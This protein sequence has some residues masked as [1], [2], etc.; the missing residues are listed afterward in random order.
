MRLLNFKWS[1]TVTGAK[2]VTR[3]PAILV[4]NHVDAMD[5]VAIV[6]KQW[7]R[8][9]AFAKIE[10]F[11]N[12]GAIFFRWMGQI[13]LRRGDEESTRWA[14]DMAAQVLA[15]GSMLGLYPEGTRSPDKKSLHKLHRRILIPIFEL[16]PEVPVHAI[17]T[18]YGAKKFGRQRVCVHLSKRLL[19]DVSSMSAAHI[20]DVIKN[21]ILES[22]GMA[23]VDAFARDIKA[24]NI[25]HTES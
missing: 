22:G 23:Y 3:G 2:N 9:T 1:V 20:V 5:P 21:E 24:S 15:D 19:I 10:V 11:E 4:G 17:T 7:W 14:L 18:T 16:H 12:R 25:L 13:P 6:M 8:V